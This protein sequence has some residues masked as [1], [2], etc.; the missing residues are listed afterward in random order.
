MKTSPEVT[1][2]AMGMEDSEDCIP[3]ES[4]YLHNTI[5][6]EGKVK[7]EYQDEL[8][9][10]QEGGNYWK[11]KPGK[12]KVKALSE[13]EPTD[14]FV[15]KKEDGTEER[16]EQFKLKM[17]LDGE[18]DGEEKIWTFSKGATELSTY[19][20]LIELATKKGNTLVNVEFTVV[21]KSDGTKKDYTI[22][23]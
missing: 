18:D 1:C 2:N 23:D 14:P 11:P 12:F 10:I 5:T 20:Q 8:K 4:S 9:K 22:I 15:K 13:L 21:V 6:K 7:M 19:G 3:G 16:T 17:G